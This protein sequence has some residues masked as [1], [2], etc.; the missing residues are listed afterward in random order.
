[1]KILDKVR[2][3]SKAQLQALSLL[4]N[5][6][7]VTSTDIGASLKIDD[8]NSYG[9]VLSSLSRNNIITPAGAEEGKRTYRWMLT[10]EVEERREEVTGLVNKILELYK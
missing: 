6:E 9:G 4:L 5:R 8:Q 10:P 3:L 2:R 1:M 7:A